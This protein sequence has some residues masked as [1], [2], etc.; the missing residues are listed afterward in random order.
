[1]ADDDAL[2]AATPS[3]LPVEDLELQVA[4]ELDRF[5]VTLAELQRWR[6]G[7]VLNLSQGPSDPVRLV[8]ETGLQRRILAEGR[9]TLVND[10]LGIELLR[11]LT[12]LDDA[13]RP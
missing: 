1:M 10:R 13:P 11:I 3:S 9:V 2:G 12:R 8:L 6:E 4:I 5:P 7:E